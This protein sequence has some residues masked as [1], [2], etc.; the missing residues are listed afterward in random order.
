MQAVIEVEHHRDGVQRRFGTDSGDQRFQ[1]DVFK[2]HLGNVDDKRRTLLLRRMEQR[3]QKVG[4]E[5]VERAERVTVLLRMGE[6]LRQRDQ[7]H[8]T[9]LLC[10]PAVIFV[11]QQP[12]RRFILINRIK[13]RQRGKKDVVVL[14]V[15]G[16]GDF[17]HQHIA[18]AGF[19]PEAVPDT[20]Q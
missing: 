10:Q 13:A 12:A 17:A 9:L 6:A 15:I 7:C 5:N 18:V 1:A 2:M 8:G 19:A 14:I 4:V 11:T 16:H 20:G 3:A